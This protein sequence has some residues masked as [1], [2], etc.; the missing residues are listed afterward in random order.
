MFAAG[1]LPFAYEPKTGEVLF[2][3]G[4]ERRDFSF[5]DFGG[6]AEKMDKTNPIETAV[7]EFVEETYGL[8]CQNAFALKNRLQSKN[9]VL[10]H[11]RT[12]NNHPYYMYVVEIDFQS[13]LRC[14]F[15]RTVEFLKSKGLLKHVEKVDVGWFSLS[16]LNG[17]KKRQVFEKTLS[18]HRDFFARL[19]KCPPS[20][21]KGLVAKN[22]EIFCEED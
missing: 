1:V 20:E 10:L 15:K 17:I 12:L 11:S 5:S 18:L 9:A 21:W 7:R 2:L 8:V 13:H 22:Q 3:L 19:A 4:K 14:Y 6:K 16:D